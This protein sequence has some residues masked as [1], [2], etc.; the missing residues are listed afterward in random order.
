M[1]L[2]R[3]ELKSA[4]CTPGTGTRNTRNH[5]PRNTAFASYRVNEPVPVQQR[6]LSAGIA[7]ATSLVL[8]VRVGVLAPHSDV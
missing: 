7:A 4:V 8:L 1:Y 6:L 2:R 5:T 3:T